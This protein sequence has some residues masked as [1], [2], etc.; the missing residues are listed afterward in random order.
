MKEVKKQ[1]FSN[2]FGLIFPIYCQNYWHFEASTSFNNQ[3]LILLAIFGASPNF[4]VPLLEESRH[5]S[6]GSRVYQIEAKNVRSQRNRPDW[7]NHEIF[8]SKTRDFG[9]LLKLKNFHPSLDPSQYSI[10][11]NKLMQAL[12]FILTFRQELL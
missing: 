2:F 12:I 1:L 4:W 10:K 9:N 3:D 6:K 7:S 8:M 11:T 5:Q